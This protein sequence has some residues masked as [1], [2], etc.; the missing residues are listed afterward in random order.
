MPYE[1][2]PGLPADLQRFVFG[3]RHA[4]RYNLSR[5]MARA[6][7]GSPFSLAGGVTLRQRFG[8]DKTGSDMLS[9]AVEELDR[10]AN[11]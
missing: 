3:A 7:R 5:A 8:S 1:R 6:F 2:L 10:V 11:C 4:D 9:K